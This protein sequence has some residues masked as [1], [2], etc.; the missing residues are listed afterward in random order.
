MDIRELKAKV[1][2]RVCLVGNVEVDTLTRGTRQQV[3]E[4][5]RGL[6]RDVAPAGGY[7]LG[8]SNT[9]PTYV[10]EPNYRAMVETA[11]EHGRYPIT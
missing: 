1:G 11:L 3:A 9:I 7:C 6:I 5:T 8:S 10:P 4:L 2:D